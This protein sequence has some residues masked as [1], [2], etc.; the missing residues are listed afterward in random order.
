MFRELQ[1]KEPPNIVIFYDGTNDATAASIWPDPPGSHMDL[2][3]LKERFERG[4]QVTRDEAFA[5][6][7]RRASLSRVSRFALAAIG[8]PLA[9]SRPFTIDQTEDPAA[10]ARRRAAQA[11]DVWLV[12]NRTVAALGQEYGFVTLFFLQPRL[13]VGEK[14]LDL[15]E[16]DILSA[17]MDDP[18]RRWTISVDREMR[19]VLGDRLRENPGAIKRVYDISDIF[20]GVTVPLYTDW[21]HIVGKGNRIVAERMFETL[22]SELCR[23]PL[24][25]PSDHVMT[26]IA[27]ACRLAELQTSFAPAEPTRIA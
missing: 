11:A 6:L 24:V 25:D 21:V 8:I 4:E 13:G 22:A 27:E 2:P 16:A 1:T 19:T 14:P 7:I 3:Q 26:Q 15:S 12:N 10:E 23:D 9:Q 17:Q 5:A 18:N 20:N